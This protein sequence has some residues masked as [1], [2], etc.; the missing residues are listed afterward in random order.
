MVKENHSPSCAVNKGICFRATVMGLFVSLGFRWCIFMLPWAEEEEEVLG[1]KW[2]KWRRADA[3]ERLGSKRSL[4]LGVLHW[5]SSITKS[6][7]APAF[8]SGRGLEPSLQGKCS[9][10][11]I[12]HCGLCQAA[13]CAHVHKYSR[14]KVRDPD[15]NVSV[16]SVEIMVV[17]TANGVLR[18]CQT[19]C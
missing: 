13:S 11:R 7:P 15:F 12:R 10:P 17:A 8:H 3:A 6:P 19:S 4:G 16:S 2:R 1:G 9:D 14:L 18:T 5:I